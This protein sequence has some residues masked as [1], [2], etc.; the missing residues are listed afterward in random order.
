VT[1]AVD[2]RAKLTALI[3]NELPEPERFELLARLEA[4]APLRAERDALRA[5]KPRIDEAF[6]ALL[7]Q[8]PLARLAAALPAPPPRRAVRRFAPSSLAAGLVLGA[9]LG[10]ALTL[11]LWR[12]PAAEED[13]TGAVVDYMKLYSP[14][15]FAALDPGAPEIARELDGLGAKIGLPLAPA[16]VAL[17]GLTF[18]TAFGLVYDGA[19]LGEI[20]LTDA[21]NAPN[22]FC[23][24]ADGA[25]PQKLKVE[26]RGAY[27]LATWAARGKRFLVVGRAEAPVAQWAQTL[28]MR[29]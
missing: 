27:A 4:E 25:P 17:S 22:L 16:D 21:S 15:T 7:D 19:P 9:A 1:T 26:T 10:A 12:G 24:L 28:S 5:A 2:D 13:W 14:D 11:A 8:A 23:I 29:L 20:V 3:D 6:S 18:K